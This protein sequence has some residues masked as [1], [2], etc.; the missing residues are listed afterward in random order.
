MEAFFN[1]L[2]ELY[3]KNNYPPNRIY[4]VDESGLTIVQSKIPQIIGHKG[5]RQVAA[6][7]SAERGSLMT[8]VVCMNATG[9]FVPQFIIFPRKNMSAQLMRGCP[10]GSV[11]VA[12]PSG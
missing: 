1:L 6:L 10:P 4:N 2:E 12:H 7:T 11:G 8:I 5:K 9:H 3:I